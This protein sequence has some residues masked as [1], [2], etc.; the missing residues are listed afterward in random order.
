MRIIGGK[1]KKKKLLSVP[2]A[3]TRPTSDRLRESLFNILSG[4]V[5]DAVVLDLFAGTGALG[6]EAMSRHAASAV[7]VDSQSQAISVI[8]KN[9]RSCSFEETTRVIKWD[10][11]RNLNCLHNRDALFS[12]VFMDPPYNLDMIS[13]TLVNLQKCRCLEQNATIVIEHSATE[14]VSNFPDSFSQTDQRLYGK[15]AVS[16]LVFKN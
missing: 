9:I 2:G 3:S 16:F 14:S 15:T 12:L 11:I 6:L 5:M 7:F 4:V 10:I 13:K 1:F 8:N